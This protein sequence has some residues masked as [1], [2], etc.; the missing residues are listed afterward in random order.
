PKNAGACPLLDNENNIR[1]AVYNI[2]LDA[3]NNAVK[4]TALI[5]EA[6]NA[7]PI[8]SNTIVN[9]LWFTDL[10][11]FNNIGS[12]LGIIA[13]ITKIEQKYKIII[14]ILPLISYLGI[15]EECQVFRSVISI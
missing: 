15:L 11:S 2:E 12:L 5:T 8:L 7:I 10:D 4:I 13:V 1:L 3:D 14:L 9:G 6:A